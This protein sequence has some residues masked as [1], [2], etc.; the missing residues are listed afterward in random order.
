MK[1]TKKTTKKVQTK[2]LPWLTSFLSGAA[3]MLGIVVLTT[4]LVFGILQ[5]RGLKMIGEM[6][7]AKLEITDNLL[8]SYFNE[9]DLVEGGS[10]N[11]MTGYGIS[12]ED[13]VFYVTFD[14]I[15]HDEFPEDYKETF[16]LSGVPIRH[17]IMYFWPSE[18]GGYSY[19]YS[20]H[21]DYYHPGGE[22]VRLDQ[23]TM[24]ELLRQD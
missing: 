4:V 5:V 19:A 12:D 13:G 14:Y 22:Y 20:Y 11:K 10:V 6:D 3:V 17:G 16:D 24:E 7:Q 21:D 8:E 23:P 2:K 15:R 1:K 18:N 9:L